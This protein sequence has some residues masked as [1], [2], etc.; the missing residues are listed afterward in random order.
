LEQVGIDKSSG[1]SKI[2]VVIKNNV[3][4]T[5]G[6]TLKVESTDDMI[7]LKTDLM[8][9]NIV[10]QILEIMNQKGL[11]QSELA[12]LIKVEE[13]YL[14]KVFSIE[15]ALSLKVIVKIQIVLGFEIII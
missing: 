13:D 1:K 5:F 14:D 4:G 2:F 12:K 9:I 3:S 15:K 10:N 7:E 8:Q 11:K 6:K